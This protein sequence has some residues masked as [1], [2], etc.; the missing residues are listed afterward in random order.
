M[1][2]S[3]AKASASKP[4]KPYP[5]FP[6]FAHATKRWAKKIQGNTHYFRPWDDP[7]GALEKYMR[8]RDALHAGLTP[9]DS[10]TVNGPNVADLCESFMLA[11]DQQRDTGEITERTRRDYLKVCKRV[12]K[13]LGKTLTSPTHLGGTYS[14]DTSASPIALEFRRLTKAV[15]AVAMQ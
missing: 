3:T 12:A 7:E 9:K 15:D 4:A 14:K 5:E 6:L 8:D 13:V 10:A 1:T 11:K 2:K